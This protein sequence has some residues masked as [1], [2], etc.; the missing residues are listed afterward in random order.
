MEWTAELDSRHSGAVLQL[1]NL[2]EDGNQFCLILAEFNNSQY[3]EL[4]ISQLSHHYPE[5]AVISATQTDDLLADLQKTAQAASVIHIIDTQQ[6][7]DD[8]E[9]YALLQRLNQRREWIAEQVNRGMVFWLF[10]EQISAFARVAPDLWAWR[11]AIVDFRNHAEDKPTAV[12]YSQSINTNSTDYADKQARLT[13]IN[14]YLASKSSYGLADADLCEEK[15]K[16]LISIGELDAAME[17]AKQRLNI[18]QDHNDKRGAADSLG[19]IADVLQARGELDAALKIRR[20][21]QLP[22]YEALGD[23][24]STAVT[25]GKIAD[26]LQARGDL[27]AALK[28]R[29]EEQLPVYE[30]LGDKRAKAVTMGKIA[31]VLEARGDLDAALKIRREEELPVYEALGDKRAKAVTMGYI[32]D[33]LQARGDLDAALKIRREEELPVYE[34]LGDKRATAVTMGKIADVLDACGE[35]DAALKIRREKQL[36]VFEALGDKRELLVTQTKLA[37][38]LQKIDAKLHAAE[39]QALLTQALQSAEQMNIPE[40][41]IIRQYL[42]SVSGK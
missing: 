5:Q 9:F 40:Q 26:V 19:Y 2:L 28:I 33:V 18:C 16:I 22:V 36:P 34:A 13:E 39:T 6:W 35:L 17:C 41:E 37:L 21:E 11:K 1:T 23:K 32:A 42:Q 27:N 24:R 38:L 4:M 12:I 3:R 30:A 10:A 14:E 8:R 20:E 29:R 15:C 25:M 7:F 31:D